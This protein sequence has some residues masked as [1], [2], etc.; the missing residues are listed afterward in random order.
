MIQF[1]REGGAGMYLILAVGLFLLG[2]EALNV[3]RLLLIKDHSEENLRIDTSSVLIGCLA[4]TFL[5]VGW[6]FLGVY[7][8]ASAVTQSHQ[9]LELLLIGA[10]ES[11]TPTILSLL[12]SAV[13]VLAHYGTRRVLHGWRAPIAK[14]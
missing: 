9:L 1:I 11:L 13:I 5:G 10:K 3:V 7:V 6:T 12:L 2:R 4:L 8:S 14:R